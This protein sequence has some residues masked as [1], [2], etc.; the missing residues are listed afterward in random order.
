MSEKQDRTG[1][2]TAADIE[3]K[4]NFNKSFAEVLGVATDART[5]AESAKKAVIK[6]DESLTA[7]EV[8]NRLTNNGQL[9]GLYK[10]DD[11][12]LFVN[13]TYIKS[14][15]ELFTKDLTMTGTFTNEVEAFIE[16]GAEEVETVKQIL[17]GSLTLTDD[18]LALYDSNGDGQITTS[19]LGNF[20]MARL[21]VISLANAPFAKKTPV[22]LTI[23]MSNPKKFIH[24][25]GKNMWG[26]EISGY[27]GINFTSIKNPE[28]EER[29][30]N[31]ET[32]LAYRKKTLW[33]G[34]WN[35]GEIYVSDTDKY[36]LYKIT[37]SG[38]GTTV[39]A[40][41]HANFIRGIG[42]YSTATPTIMSY[43]FAATIDGDY[44][45]FVAC[46]ELTHSNNTIKN[47]TVTSIEGII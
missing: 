26:R 25:S 6:L 21:G 19:D 9:Q 28:T 32:D 42:G 14:I 47:C 8:F 20:N 18:L 12:N 45:T 37:M 17:Y 46:N 38:M 11:G 40:M 41:R 5:E 34:S 15:E 31:I 44:W 3:R 36:V 4:Y 13:A 2:R 10:D 1:A 7:E 22:K 30:E 24:Y 16:P 43:Q 27:I 29:L 35:A 23:D 33:S 39:L